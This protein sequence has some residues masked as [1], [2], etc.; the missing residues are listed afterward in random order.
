MRSPDQG[1]PGAIDQPSLRRWPAHL[2]PS[3]E[4]LLSLSTASKTSTYLSYLELNTIRIAC[5][6]NTQ[7]ALF[8]NRST[9]KWPNQ[10]LCS[11]KTTR[12]VS[13]DAVSSNTDHDVTATC[14]LTSYCTIAH[15]HANDDAEKEYDR[16][17]D[18]A[19][20]EAAKRSS[21]FDK[22][23]LRRSLD[24]HTASSLCD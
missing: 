11:I 12:R 9:S 2:G 14:V 7:F 24:T 20:A 1:S 10:S 5:F 18:L 3:L 8:D 17:R 21:C 4:E 19:R 16:L 13:V 15:S 22:V 6:F 23:Q